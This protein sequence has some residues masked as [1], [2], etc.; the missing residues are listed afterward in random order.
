[1]RHKT[2]NIIVPNMKET[3]TNVWRLQNIVVRTPMG[4]HYHTDSLLYLVLWKDSLHLCIDL[5]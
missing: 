3:L 2:K 1:M 4:V 5:P